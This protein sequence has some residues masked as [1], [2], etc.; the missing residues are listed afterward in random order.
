MCVFVSVFVAVPLALHRLGV[1]TAQDSVI[2]PRLARCTGEALL[3]AFSDC[4]TR[5]RQM[6]EWMRRMF[7]SLDAHSKLGVSSVTK[8]SL[9]SVGISLFKTVIFDKKKASLNSTI[10][11]M[12]TRLRDGEV[13]DV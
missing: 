9:T 10:Q 5:H 3:K 6:N 4:W 12:I 11:T 2:A 7:S 13:V 8:P 1:S